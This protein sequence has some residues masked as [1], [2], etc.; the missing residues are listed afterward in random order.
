MRMAVHR[1]DGSTTTIGSADHNSE[2]IAALPIWH[3][4]RVWSSLDLTAQFTVVASLIVGVGLAFLGSWVAERVKNTVLKHASV[5]SAFYMTHVIE[6]HAQDLVKGGELRPEAIAALDNLL[7]S[8]L[9]HRIEVLKFWSSTGKILYSSN[10][11]EIGQS[12]P[13]TARLRTA[14][15]GTVNAQFEELHDDEHEHQRGL[16][17]PLMEIYSPVFASGTNEVITVAEFYER[18]TDLQVALRRA[19]TQAWMAVSIFALATLFALFLVVRQGNS[20]ILRQRETMLSQIRELSTLLEANQELRVNLTQAHTRY[21]RHNDQFL[22][23][24]GAELHDG[25]A[26]L[27]GFA[28]LRLDSILSDSARTKG[29]APEAEEDEEVETLR[30]ALHEALQEIRILSSGLHLPELDGKS[31][32]AIVDVAIKGH[33]RRSRVTVDRSFIGN[34][35]ETVPAAVKICLYRFTQEAL[36]NGQRHAPG[37][38]QAV[39]LRLSEDSITIE[40]SDDGPGFDPDTALKKSES[41]GLAGLRDRVE[42]L[43]GRFEIIS[44]SSSGTTLRAEFSLSHVARLEVGIP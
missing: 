35:P 21:A 30:E 40:V 20:T 22:R 38:H 12:Y 39:Y 33:E 37:S 29:K 3:P 28:L 19:Q 11:K 4:S 8:S 23:R 13:V 7:K 41:L 6:Q 14:W 17:V 26:Q 16:G 43:G 24:L 32:Q 27:I 15:G 9:S 5:E 36:V 1:G 34:A 44:D 18:A 31:A 42:S 25:P 2:R 10:P